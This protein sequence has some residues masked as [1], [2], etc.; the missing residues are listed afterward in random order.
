MNNF[1]DEVNELIK[2]FKINFN[3]ELNEDENNNSNDD[4]NNDDDGGD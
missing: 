3:S 2:T 4:N 1:N